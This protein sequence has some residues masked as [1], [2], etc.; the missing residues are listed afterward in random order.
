MRLNHRITSYLQT[1]QHPP[2]H[3]HHNS[4]LQK[5]HIHPQIFRYFLPFTSAKSA[6][7]ARDSEETPPYS[8][9]FADF[10][11]PL[12]LIEVK[13]SW[14]WT[15]WCASLLASKRRP[16]RQR[17]RQRRRGA[18]RRWRPG[19]HSW[20]AATRP[21]METAFWWMMN[22]YRISIYHISMIIE[23]QNMDDAWL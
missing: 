1:C 7:S 6:K 18:W 9:I 3:P 19:R 15:P 14:C 13:G 17:Q 20:G 16:P 8:T 2:R 11:L 23:N 21:K 12:R 5:L 4:K 22:D 10:L